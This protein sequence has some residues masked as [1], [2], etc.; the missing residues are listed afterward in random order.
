MRSKQR[1]ASFL[2]WI[3][4]AAVVSGI[5]LFAARIVPAYVDYRT[6]VTLIDALP[7]DKVHTMTKGEIKDALRKRFLINNIRDLDVDDIIEI[8]RK[9]AGTTLVLKYEVRQ[10]LIYNISVVVSFDR[11]FD[12]H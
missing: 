12:Y 11:R 4:I 7:A 10:P 8:D 5:G 6:I 1:G 3:L 2:S 9:R